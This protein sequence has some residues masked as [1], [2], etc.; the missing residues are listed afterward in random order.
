MN[1]TL[2]GMLLTASTLW[3][4]AALAEPVFDGELALAHIVSQVS[5]GPR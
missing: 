2:T 5:F 3:A 1:K 4:N